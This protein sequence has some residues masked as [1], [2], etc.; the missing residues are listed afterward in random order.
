[1]TERIM[2]TLGGAFGLL[3]LIVASLGV[4]GVLAFQVTRRTNELGVRMALGATRGAMMRLVLSQ[5]AW[6]VV[7]GLVIGI[8]VALLL[9]RVARNVLF[10]LSPTEPRVFLIAALMLASAATLAAW[11]PARRAGRVDP[12]IAL[13]RE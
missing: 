1:V 3:A 4:F 2:A 6:M 13:R 10:D 9:T 8:S 12:L 5:V 11:L 7:P